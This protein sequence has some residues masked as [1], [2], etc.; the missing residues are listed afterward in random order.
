MKIQ[1]SQ[2]REIPD[3]IKNIIDKVVKSLAPQKVILFGSY[4]YGNVSADSDVDLLIILDTN[5]KSAERQ[6]VVS[7]L[8]HPRPFPVDIIVKTPEEII[9]AKKRID[10]FMNEILEKGV[11]LYG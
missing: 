9:E 10:P 4:A 7:R 5:L 11:V 3:L 2:I 8:I 1:H 6:R